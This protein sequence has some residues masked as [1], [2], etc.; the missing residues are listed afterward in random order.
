ME[1]LAEPRLRLSIDRGALQ[2]NF[3]WFEAC[4]GVP[5]A[6]AIKADGYGLGARQVADALAAAGCS[7]FC[8]STWAEA[9]ALGDLR[10]EI[11]VLHGYVDEDRAA[12]EILPH[13]RPVL[14]TEGQIAAWF[15]AFPGRA[16]D[17]MVDTGMNRL[18]LPVENAGALA[19][20][21]I[22]TLHSHLACADEPDHPL[23]DI[24]L[25]RFRAVCAMG[26]ARRHA[27]ANSA[28]VCRGRDFSFDRV[29]PGLGLYGGVAHPA[30]KVERVVFP[31]ARVLQLRDV[32]AG[33]GVGYGSTWKSRADAQI[34][35]VNLG[36]ADGLPREI[37]PALRFGQGRFHVAGRLSMD[38]IAIDV[39]GGDVAEGDW[40]DLDFDLPRMAAEG[41]VSQYELL[42]GL[43]RRYVR[44]WS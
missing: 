18:G 7:S 23:T 6:A 21:P 34:A 16:A 27:L 8:V 2:R 24:Q 37:A 17:A 30:A 19:G 42:T 12:A 28:G 5:A 39:T 36:Y 44:D 22:D 32:R 4:A 31:S 13:A 25:S 26:L 9:L 1:S 38:L 29:R 35:V 40:L 41:A 33:A 10:A 14:C 11:L 43:S 3:H 15:A 20:L